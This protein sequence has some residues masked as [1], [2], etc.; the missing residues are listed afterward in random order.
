[1]KEGFNKLIHM[2]SV[3][4]MYMALMLLVACEPNES[5]TPNNSQR[6]KKSVKIHDDNVNGINLRLNNINDEKLQHTTE[7]FYRGDGRLDSLVVFKNEL[8][9]DILRT[10]KLRYLPDNTI[11]GYYYEN[12]LITVVNYYYDEQNRLIEYV[13]TVY[14]DS[15]NFLDLGLYFT[16][17]NDKLNILKAVNNNISYYMYGFLYDSNDN[18]YQYKYRIYVNN[19]PIA[20]DSFL[21]K[22]IYDYSKTSQQRINLKHDM[23]VMKYMYI[24]GVNIIPLMGLNMG[25]GNNNLLLE[26]RESVIQSNNTVNVIKFNYTMDGSNNIK[27]K[28]ITLN[29]TISIHYNFSY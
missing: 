16:Y 6:V 24:G 9:N 7:F 18:I 23:E 2:R 19:T 14:T 27:E 25:K 22:H 3:L 29:D 20:S 28:N 26:S 15:I 1:M 13:Y 12:D 5:E 8:R 11:R 21:V 4:Y 10:L 17:I